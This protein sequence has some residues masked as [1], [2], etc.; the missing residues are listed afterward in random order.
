M[1][2]KKKSVL[3]VDNGLFLHFAESIA[4]S[5]GTVYYWSPWVCSFPKS[6]SLIVGQGV[7]GVTR[8]KSIDEVVD[9]VDL[10][11]FLDVGYDQMQAR[12]A[13]SGKLVWGAR[14]GEQLELDR[15][16]AKEQAADLD[17]PIGPY[18]VLKGVADLRGYL[19]ENNDQFVKV[20]TLR[21]DAETFYSPEYRMVEPRL[22]ELEYVLGAR[23]NWT[24]F[25]VEAAIHDAI[26]IGYDG[27]TVDGMF[28][29]KS[30]FG[31]EIKDKGY[32]G[33]V[34]PYDGLPAALIDC[35]AK[36]SPYLREM[37]YRGIFSCEVRV[38]GSDYFFLDPC[39]RMPSPPGELYGVMISNWADILWEGA[40]GE[41]VQPNY[42]AKWGAVLIMMSEW[43]RE[44]WQPVDYPDAIA[45][46]V[47]LKN[48]AVID[49]QRYVIPQTVCPMD[50]LGCVVG[51]GD[52]PEAAIRKTQRN[53]EQVE[54]LGIYCVP[55][56]LGDA[57]AH[58][59]DLIDE[60]E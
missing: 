41:L 35:N 37:D 14:L 5:F 18:Q 60:G 44:H 6:N 43:S 58:Y 27:Y 29:K 57:L 38:K 22:D 59:N 47:R 2:Y 53:A 10:I 17:I 8:V 33:Q 46:F 51:T 7:P 4:E 26:E 45:D 56:V 9:D 21:G 52:T 55:A 28:P 54:G 40:T 1:N 11:V 24:D 3:V 34:V 30:L 42:V 50:I 36:L 25:I 48:Y 31:V 13:R 16:F 20:S 32:L 15:I 12:L 19:K 49:G 39:C 23:K